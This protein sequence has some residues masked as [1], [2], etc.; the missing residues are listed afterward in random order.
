MQT[1]VTELNPLPIHLTSNNVKKI[2][3]R[4]QTLQ[5]IIVAWHV[6]L[7]TFFVK[8]TKQGQVYMQNT[9]KYRGNKSKIP[10]LDSKEILESLQLLSDAL[11][12]LWM[13]I[14]TVITGE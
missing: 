14:V 9:T 4:F 11:R 3:K 12:L 2:W 7:S 10:C 1:L 5:A 8:H 6:W 13:A